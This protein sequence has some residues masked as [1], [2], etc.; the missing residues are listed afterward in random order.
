ML[1]AI[2]LALLAIAAVVGAGDFSG[3]V[4]ETFQLSGPSDPPGGGG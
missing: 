3:T 1:R 2:V 4:G